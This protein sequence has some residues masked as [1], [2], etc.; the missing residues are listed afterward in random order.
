L[1]NASMLV[2]HIPIFSVP[3]LWHHA[4]AEQAPDIPVVDQC[5]VHRREEDELV[6]RRRRP[7]RIFSAF[8]GCDQAAGISPRRVADAA[9]ER[10][11][12]VDDKAAVNRASAAARPQRAG[13]DGV[14]SRASCIAIRTYA[15]SR[16]SRSASSRQARTSSARLCRLDRR[17]IATVRYIIRRP[18]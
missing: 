1:L 13:N 3:L 18:H 9:G 5:A 4:A 11:P 15:G 2:F 16:R 12:A 17:R 8:I 7:R 6:F 10:P 14:N